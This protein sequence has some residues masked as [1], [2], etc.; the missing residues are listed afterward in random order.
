VAQIESAVREL[1][2]ASVRVVG[3][4]MNAY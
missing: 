1:T 2:D 4:V 3:T